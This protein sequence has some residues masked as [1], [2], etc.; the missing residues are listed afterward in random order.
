LGYPPSRIAILM[1]VEAL[2]FQS[3]FDRRVERE[4]D[5]V[6]LTVIGLDD[7]KTNKR[8]VGRERDIADLSEL[9][10]NVDA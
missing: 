7:L 9:D 4:V 6:R 10:R 8:A 1:D 5:G 2:E 3:A